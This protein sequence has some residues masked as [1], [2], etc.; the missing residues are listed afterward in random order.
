MRVLAPATLVEAAEMRSAEPGAVLAAGTTDLLPAWHA[1]APRP[2]CLI[3]LAGIEEMRRIDIADDA[4]E[5]G[6]L[7]T[8]ADI[9]SHDGIGEHLPALAAAARSIG[10]PAVRNMGTI[11]GNVANASPAADMPPPLLAYGA[12]VKLSSASAERTVPLEGFF[13]GYRRT[14]VREGEIIRSLTVPLPAAGAISC[15]EKLG[16]RRAQSIAKISL[17]GCATCSGT[18][19]GIRLAT[20]SMAEIPR[21][22]VEVEGVLEGRRLDARLVEEA[23]HVASDALKPIDDV[24]STAAYRSHALGVLITRFLNDIMEGCR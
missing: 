4:I 1:G 6:A 10:A 17:A 20:G 11:G 13:L 22:L 3:L 19:E 16:T 12:S 14:D 8:H 21:R 23:V 18:I 5:I 2:E 24:R 7:A 9:A 15:F